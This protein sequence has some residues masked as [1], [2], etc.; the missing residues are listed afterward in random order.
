M[1]TIIAD[2]YQHSSQPVGALVAAK[3]TDY[4]VVRQRIRKA[5]DQSEPL[6]VYA[7][8]PVVLGWLSD[9]RRY[10]E[11]CVQWQEVDPSA[12]FI[13][14]FGRSPTDPFTPRRI[15]NLKLATLPQP[16]T[17]VLVHPLSW[18]L[19]HRLDPV[20]QYDT[21]PVNHTA[22][23]V[24]WSFRHPAPLD[25]DLAS[26]VQA[27][28]DRW[29]A[30]NPIYHALHATSLVQ[31]GASLLVR[32][33]LQRYNGSWRKTQ[34]WGGLPIIAGDPQPDAVATALRAH[35][36]GIRSYW[37]LQIVGTT[38]NS[39][40]I[41][42]ALIQMSG[43]SESELSAVQ[44]MLSRCPTL[45]DSQLLRAIGKCFAHFSRADSV[46]RSLAERV[47]PPTPPLPESD[48]S[49]ERWLNWATQHYIPYFAWVI[50]TGHDR[51]YQQECA[52]RYSDWLYQQYP[53]WLNN[54]QSPLLLRQYQAIQDLI[55]HD[56]R[57]MVVWL[58]IDG[59]TWWQGDIMRETCER[60]GLHMQ[61][62]FP[63]I[64]VLPSI[65]SISK[66]AL[67][68][69]QTNMN[70]IQPTIADAA[71][72]KLALS[73]IPAMVS[74]D[75][76]AAIEALRQRDDIRVSIIL[77]NLIDTLAHQTS[78]FTDNTGIRGSL[79]DLARGLSSAQQ[80]CVE[81]GQ[82]LHIFIGSDHGSTL[83]PA[84]ALSVALP[85]TVHEIDDIWE[86][87]QSSQDE[88]KPGTRAAATDLDHIPFI[89]TQVWYALDHHRFQLDRHY[90]VP[91]GY[92]YIK[93]RPTG[94]THGGLTPE[95]T[96]VPLMQLTPEQVNLI[97]IECELR[98][99]LRVG[100]AGSITAVLKNLNPFLVQDLHLI[101]S[102]GPDEVIIMQIKPLE[103]YEVELQFAAVM[104]Q[105]KTL[106]VTYELRYNAFGRPEYNEGQAHISLR[107]L[108]TQDTSFDDMFS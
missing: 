103:H 79:E 89:D 82:K 94:W 47:A 62:L 70:L 97:P 101:V 10:P 78:T 84:D 19:G 77:F 33:A 98:G 41:N 8:D 52:L 95:E 32:W 39:E 15:A 64:A 49:T 12:E 17:G 44:T 48:W 35:D 53:N 45:L 31:D 100:Q 102:G 86:A 37:N 5:I 107:R 9:L 3:T 88:V 74:Y 51:A 61:A 26:L 13:S 71:R 7:T 43:L 42:A 87:E 90:V 105:G 68:T 76:S 2:R 22:S 23:L 83:L 20:W 46:L 67:V 99:T 63:G 1:I 6:T 28:L 38:I 75:L 59:L 30:Q 18:I 34:V 4:I 85:N 29:S 66:R 55:E 104:G 93:R 92:G 40:F 36:Q 54:D 57:V 58:I 60:Y 27:Q 14:L 69:G 50:R 72:V 80:A 108:Q 91:R 106:L 16:P 11:H 65:T 96:I 73:K 56:K 81:H 21:P 24:V 25:I